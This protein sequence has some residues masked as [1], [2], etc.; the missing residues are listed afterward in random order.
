MF[1]NFQS[2]GCIIFSTG[3]KIQGFKVN[4]S[5]LPRFYLFDQKNLCLG[6]VFKPSRFVILFHFSF[7]RSPLHLD[8]SDLSLVTWQIIIYR[9]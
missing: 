9:L 3:L 8:I 7:L 4:V 6:Q 1:L 5:D 2:S